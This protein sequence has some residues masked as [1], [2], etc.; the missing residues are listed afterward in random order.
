[1]TELAVDMRRLVYTIVCFQCL[2]QLTAGSAYQRYLKLFSE[3]LLICIC[4]RVVFSFF[5][6]IDENTSQTDRL[7]KEWSKEWEMISKEQKI[8]DSFYYIE[9]KIVNEA[10][11]IY[12]REGDADV[13]EYETET[14]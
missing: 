10:F 2:L 6:F 12:E 9:D 4:C 14:E 5:G 1:M 7:Y 13:W 3:L 8:Y 11:G